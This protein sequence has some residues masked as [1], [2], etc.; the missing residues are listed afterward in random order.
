MFFRRPS[1]DIVNSY[2]LAQGYDENFGGDLAHVVVMQHVTKEKIDVFIDAF[3]AEATSVNSVRTNAADESNEVRKVLHDG[4]LLIQ[5]GD[6]Y[7]NT[8]GS[9]TK[10]D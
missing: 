1:E 8:A 4:K 5:S 2:I 9:R 3:K 10:Y 7:Y 6:T